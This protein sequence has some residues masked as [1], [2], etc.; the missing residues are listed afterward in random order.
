M[1]VR[2]RA[3]PKHH[4]SPL[5]R[6]CIC[7]LWPWL[8]QYCNN[9]S[10]HREDCGH[11][12]EAE[13]GCTNVYTRYWEPL[14][15]QCLQTLF[16][17]SW[18]HEGLTLWCCHPSQLPQ[19]SMEFPSSFVGSVP[20]VAYECTDSAVLCADRVRSDSVWDARVSERLSCSEHAGRATQTRTGPSASPYRTSHTLQV[21]L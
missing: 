17:P 21:R 10:E 8:S 13:S 19:A 7:P 4:F 1:L 11:Q 5:T 14:R 18:F 12:W 20:L 2:Y 16:I 3:A 15:A 9:Q 6:S